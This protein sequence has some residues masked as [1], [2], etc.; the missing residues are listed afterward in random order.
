MCAPPSTAAQRNATNL[1]PSEDIKAFIEPYAQ[2]F[3]NGQRSPVLRN[4]SQYGMKYEDIFFPS[5]DG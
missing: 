4:P 2:L 5:L 3:K 1:E